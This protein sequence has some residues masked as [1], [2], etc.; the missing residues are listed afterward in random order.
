[1]TRHLA[2]LCAVLL[3]ITA[4]IFGLPLQATADDNVHSSHEIASLPCTDV[5][6]IGVRGSGEDG[7]EGKTIPAVRRR[8]TSAYRGTSTSLYL[9]Y[10]AVST[11]VLTQSDIEGYLLDNA[12][13]ES[14][15]FSSVAE[16]VQELDRVLRHVATSCPKEKIVVVGFSQG[17]QV[18][19]STLATSRAAGAITATLLLGNPSHYPGQHV[20][21]LDG[22]VDTASFGM[23]A[24]LEYLREREKELNADSR[25]GKLSVV[26]TH[27]FDLYDGR[28][29]TADIAASLRQS[30]TVIP[31]AYYAK[32]FSVCAKGD[33]VC[34][35]APALSRIL[36]N[37]STPELEINQAR[38]IHGGYSPEMAPRTF[39]A[40]DELLGGQTS[41]SASPSRPQVTLSTISVSRVS[42]PSTPRAVA[43][44]GRSAQRESDTATRPSWA[45]FILTVAVAAG[46]GALLG[47]AWRKP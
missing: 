39:A 45:T 9:D 12:A 32:T 23:Q 47:R 38:P 27:V 26:M 29:Q 14:E 42:T 13:T 28:L 34:D 2:R 37:S 46:I 24:L 7:V 33:V 6:F 44:P 3:G 1:M 20:R 17:A 19:T 31:P 11:H 15:F 36:S 10:P 4:I 35:F 22:Q 25:R 16:G 40:I 8:I 21:E 30:G 5:L 41:V 43:A 18:V